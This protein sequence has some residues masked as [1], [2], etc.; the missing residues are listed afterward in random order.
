MRKHFRIVLILVWFWNTFK[1][2]PDFFST[3]MFLCL[4]FNLTY[5]FNLMSSDW[6]PFSAEYTTMLFLRHFST[7][8]SHQI[9]RPYYI[10]NF[11]WVDEILTF[12]LFLSSGQQHWYTRDEGDGRSMTDSQY[13]GYSPGGVA[14]AVAASAR[15]KPAAA[16]AQ[17]PPPASLAARI[18]HLKLKDYMNDQEITVLEEKE[19]QQQ[20]PDNKPQQPKALRP[21]EVAHYINSKFKMPPPAASSSESPVSAAGAH[22][23]LVSPSVSTGSGNTKHPHNLWSRDRN[24]GLTYTGMFSSDCWIWKRA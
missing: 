15:A 18:N 17:S 24:G 21:L 16:A 12:W 3:D 6:C 13:S 22:P 4:Y 23:P 1:I 8:S 14:A 5:F 9:K 11:E 10:I 20:Q 19:I 2:K 7:P